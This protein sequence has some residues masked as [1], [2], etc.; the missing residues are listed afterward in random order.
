MIVS[1]LG[2]GSNVIDTANTRPVRS[3]L[4]D[5][6]KFVTTVRLSQPVQW[7]N[8]TRIRIRLYSN[9][10]SSI[11][12][13]FQ[14]NGV[15]VLNGSAELAR[16]T[17]SKLLTEGDDTWTSERLPTADPNGF[18][19]VASGWQ[20]SVLSGDSMRRDSTAYVVLLWNDGQ[21]TRVGLS[22]RNTEVTTVLTLTVPAGRRMMDLS[23]AFL[24]FNDDNPLV[25]TAGTGEALTGL[26][27]LAATTDTWS[28]REMT[29]RAVLPEGRSSLAQLSFLDW[30]KNWSGQQTGTF[31]SSNVIAL[32]DRFVVPAGRVRKARLFALVDPA[33]WETGAN[34]NQAFL[35]AQLNFPGVRSP[36]VVTP[37]SARSPYGLGRDSM[38]FSQA[39]VGDGSRLKWLELNFDWPSSTS[40]L[41]TSIDFLIRP[42]GLTGL[43]AGTARIRVLGALLGTFVGAGGTVENASLP[44]RL[45]GLTMLLA[46]VRPTASVLSSSNRTITFNINATQPAR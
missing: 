7:R 36:V 9:N 42:A 37:F 38:W 32:R 20:L 31:H 11:A 21:T 30:R 43:Y 33:D 23:K 18:S 19:Q 3:S 44:D 1:L 14:L 40:T 13:G 22:T 4:T 39:P 25:L 35:T 5:A 6:T 29:L 27:G 24:F 41:P 2:E 16:P 10:G 45:G 34:P 15:R 26:E 17:A 8:V 12:P 28:V 46:D